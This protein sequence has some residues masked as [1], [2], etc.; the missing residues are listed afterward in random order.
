[1]KTAKISR[2]CEYHGMMQFNWI[3]SLPL[4]HQA[5]VKFGSQGRTDSLLGSGPS[6]TGFHFY[7]I[8]DNEKRRM[9]DDL[10]TEEGEGIAEIKNVEKKTVPETT[11]R[12]EM[13]GI[14]LAT[15]TIL[16]QLTTTTAK[17]DCFFYE[18]HRR[19][20]VTAKRLAVARGWGLV[21]WG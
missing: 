5:K 8:D 17:F 11:D 3:V 19:M 15:T 4:R 6:T 2:Y 21:E 13:N 18:A 20:N 7:W 9:N 16:R 12:M 10:V 1:M 14:G